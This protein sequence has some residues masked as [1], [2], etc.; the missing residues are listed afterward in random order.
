MNDSEFTKL[1]SIEINFLYEK[2]ESMLID[3]DEDID[4][5]NDVLYI[6]TPKGDYVINRHSPTKQ[7]WLS[8]PL[9]NAGYF[10]FNENHKE[11]LDKNNIS[12]KRRL[13]NDL[14]IFI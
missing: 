11:W 5:I 9:S 8:S 2:I 1:A 7:I 4:L 3:E 13:S 14:G 10:N 12:L 6:Y